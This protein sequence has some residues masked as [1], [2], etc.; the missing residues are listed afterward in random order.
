[1]SSNNTKDGPLK[2]WADAGTKARD[3]AGEFSGHLK[4]N[5]SLPSAAEAKEIGNRLID[6]RTKEELKDAVS[7]AARHTG[8]SLR[9]V[10]GSVKRAA[11]STKQGEKVDD[12]RDALSEALSASMDSIQEK[13]AER[14]ECRAESRKKAEPGILEGEVIAEREE[15]R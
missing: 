12:L 11:S 5:G 9:E 13:L 2:K 7:D 8:Q 6:A 1:M 3:L 10:G 4:E 15:D 14:R